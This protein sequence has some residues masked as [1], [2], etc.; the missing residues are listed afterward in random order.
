MEEID[1][2]EIARKPIPQSF[3]IK[4]I[5][6]PAS[7]EAS[8]VEWRGQIKHVPSG[9]SKYFRTLESILEFIVPYLEQMGVKL[10]RP[11]WLTRWWRR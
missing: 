10:D 7:D 8:S 5:V 4:F 2:K 6:E 9:E 11:S 3:I 1:P